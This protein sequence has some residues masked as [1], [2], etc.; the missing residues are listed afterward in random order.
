[1]I[2]QYTRFTPM[3]W[4]ILLLILAG[5][6]ALLL[7]PDPQTLSHLDISSSTYR[8]ATFLLLIPYGIIWYAA[9]YAYAKLREYI[10]YLGDSREGK[11]FRK[12]T[13]GMGILAFGLILPT[14]VSLIMGSAILERDSTNA[15]SAIVNR[16]LVL[17]FPL[18]SLLF[19][20]SGTS[21]LVS[22]T[23]IRVNSMGLRLLAVPFLLLSATFVY[24]VMHD[25]II[26]RSSYPIN[27]FFLLITIVV[28]YLYTWF[29]GFISSFELWKYSRLVKGVL[30]KKF[31]FQFSLGIS[32]AIVGSI[33]IQFISSTVAIRVSK[34]LYPLLVVDYMLLI[35]V[36][37]GLALV[38]L[39]TQKLKK[40]E[41]V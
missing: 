37:I 2:K 3:K 18:I 35:I 12:I 38:A 26:H 9:F 39:A 25:Y 34:T 1:M 8:L 41:E 29:L 36:A 17:L 30:Y 27:S 16:Y 14:I 22:A 23:K 6:L 7:P 21:S 4:Y 28:P 15:A 11:A 20:S 40:I 32:V 24:L 10:S 33:A 19:I 31:S 13:I 5:G